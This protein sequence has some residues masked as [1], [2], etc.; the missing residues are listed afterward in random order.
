MRLLFARVGV[1]Y[2]PATGLPIESQTVTQMVD[3]VLA[4][5]EGTRL[6]LLA[7]DRARPQGRVP[8][9]ARRTAEEG[10]PARQDQ[11]PLLRDRGS[12]QARQEVQARHRRGGRPDRRARRYRQPPRRFLRDGARIGR[13]PRHRGVCRQAARRHR[14]R[15]ARK[16]MCRARPP[17]RPRRKSSRTKT[18]RTSASSSPRAS[19]VRSRA[20]RSTRSSR[21][22]S[23]SMLRPAPAPTATGSAPSCNSSPTSSSPT[24]A[25]RSRTA[26]SY[27]GPRPGAT[28][29]YYAQ[30]LE[31]IAK[32]YKVS[33][34][35]PWE[36]LPQEGAGR[37]PLRHRRGGDL[38]S[39][40]RTACGS[41]RTEKAFEGVIGNI[42]RRWRETDSAWVREELSRYQARSPLRRPAAATA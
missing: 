23:P 30:T 6:Y 29:P 11:R 42:E 14:P 8:Q 3:R 22:S 12:P 40:T 1:P 18:R 38:A 27:P 36:E 39:S 10:L 17:A 5:P 16:A 19:P 7:P 28:S 20:S 24:R 41:Y 2:S 37:H 33:M 26:P 35:T 4:L 34:R 13:R 21:A 9:G 32:H 25:R 31:A 15:R